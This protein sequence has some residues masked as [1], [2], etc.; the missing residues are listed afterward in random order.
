MSQ[1]TNTYPHNTVVPT[2]AEEQ[3]EF[4]LS[5]ARHLYDQH[6]KEGVNLFYKK[7]TQYKENAEW[8]MG[9][10]SAEHLREQ[11][12]MEAGD[13]D[14]F[15]KLDFDVPSFIPRFRDAGVN[16]IL[17]LTYR[18]EVSATDK[19]SINRKAKYR[20]EVEAMVK[21]K[22]LLEQL[23]P[24]LAQLAGEGMV[25]PSDPSMEPQMEMP[26]DLEE[27]KLW[28]QMPPRMREEVAMEMFLNK[29][30]NVNDWE[31]VRQRWCEDLVDQSVAVTK[32]YL[33]EAG[34]IRL[35]YVNPASFIVGFSEHSDFR[36]AEFMG[37]IV[38]K[39]FHEIKKEAGDQFK[40][41]VW[42][43]LKKFSASYNNGGSNTDKQIE[44][45]DLEFR[46][47]RYLVTEKKET[48]YGTEATYLKPQDYNAPKNSKY[49]REVDKS[50]YF[51]VARVKW[52]VGTE[53]VYDFGI[54]QDMKRDK[55]NLKVAEFSY[56]PIAVGMK[57]GKNKSLVERMIPVEKN[58][59]R[60]LIKLQHLILEAVPKGIG[61]EVGSLEGVFEGMA[62]L[63][64][65]RMFKQKGT[66][67]YRRRDLESGEEMNGAPLTELENGMA[68]DVERL[69]S[70]VELDIRQLEDVTG[71]NRIAA[72]GAPVSTDLNGTTA[73]AIQ[74]TNKLLQ[75]YYKADQRTIERLMRGII[76]RMPDAFKRDNIRDFYAS[77]IGDANAA[78]LSV[79]DT[80][81]LCDYD[82]SAQPE[83]DEEEIAKLEQYITNALAKRDASNQGGI[84]LSDAIMAREH[85]KSSTKLAWQY[86]TLREKKLRELD[87]QQAQ[88]NTEMN[89]QQNQAAAEQ[90]AQAKLQELQA[91]FELKAQFS[92]SEWENKAN[93]LMLQHRLK[94][95][96]LRITGDI[97][98]DH[99]EQQG[100]IEKEHMVLEPTI[101]AEKQ[102]TNFENFDKLKAGKDIGVKDK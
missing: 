67:P 27:L 89:M 56:H 35:R 4:F 91:E 66:M 12:S 31:E 46:A 80:A 59:Q 3:K 20:T 44:V 84:T 79:F 98:A 82:V 95:E 73:M 15:V 1:N 32:D 64:I 41:E 40:P 61:I 13:G 62:P 18:P 10:K 22:P 36:N 39:N 92:S 43:E 6:E 81:H 68:R 33:D 25:G 78:Y 53:Y 88:Q 37:E 77:A 5:A 30:L 9:S 83:P 8:A 50:K 75:H 26:Q 2:G 7:R 94:M 74:G 29:T 86:L 55:R 23:A 97:K 21:L 45:L 47:E 38:P 65:V 58:I 93:Y 72:A 48:K 28:E 101:W 11:L 76:L 24:E 54:Q 99:I 14:E 16:S 102:Q 49:K 42:E 51:V 85:L 87:A 52:I 90:A 17:G 34:Y 57:N 60:K 70:M 96:E 63:D 100:E 19:T 69:M 71:I